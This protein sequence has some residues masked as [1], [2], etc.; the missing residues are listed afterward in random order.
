MAALIEGRFCEPAFSLELQAHPKSIGEG[1]Q[2]HLASSSRGNFSFAYNFHLRFFRP[3]NA[4]GYF[5]NHDFKWML[6]TAV[7]R[8]EDMKLQKKGAR[9]FVDS[10]FF[11]GTRVDKKR[12]QKPK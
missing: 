10:G 9:I 2:R 11:Y 5:Y 3:L 6:S 12:H 4:V 1:I 7:L 8:V